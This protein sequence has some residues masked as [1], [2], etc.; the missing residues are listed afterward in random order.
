MGL[1]VIAEGIETEDQAALL[2][3]MGCLYGQGF[4]FSP[5]IPSDQARDWL[6]R[7]WVG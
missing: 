2:H 7:D 6:G 1:Q 5:P 3:A 4:F